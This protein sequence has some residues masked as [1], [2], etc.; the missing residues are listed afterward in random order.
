DRGETDV[1][2]VVE[3]LKALHHQFP[4]RGRSNL[5]LA[6][7][8]Q[9]P[10]DPRNHSLDALWVDRPLAKRNFHRAHQL[11]AI[12]GNAPAAALEHHKLTQLDMLER[13]EAATA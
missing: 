2:D 9:S 11:V 8:L 1:S 10:H 3:L 13:R 12:E 6:R 5:V 7:A 4:D